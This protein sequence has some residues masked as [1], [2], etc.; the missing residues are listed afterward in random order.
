VASQDLLCQL[1][2][3]APNVIDKKHQDWAHQN[4]HDLASSLGGESFY[5]SE[6]VDVEKMLQRIFHGIEVKTM[7][8]NKAG[9]VRMSPESV[10][11]KLEWLKQHPEGARLHTI[12][13]DHREHVGKERPDV[14]PCYYRRGV[15]SM[16]Q[17][18]MLEVRDVQ[19]LLKLLRTAD[20]DLPE[21][22]RPRK[23]LI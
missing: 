3:P 14:F 18:D 5:D 4:E 1:L 12:V 23:A 2:A 13:F 21:A 17:K 22:A 9:R 15:G 16:M 6:P 7:L 8:Y 20:D 11:R 19:H 10:Q